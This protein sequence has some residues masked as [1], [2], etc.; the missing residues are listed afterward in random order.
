M[1]KIYQKLYIKNTYGIACPINR[2]LMQN[3]VFDIFFGHDSISS[4]RKLNKWSIKTIWTP[5]WLYLA[6]RQDFWSENVKSKSVGHDRFLVA[7]K[8]CSQELLKKIWIPPSKRA[9]GNN[10]EK[11]IESWKDRKMGENFRNIEKEI[12][13]RVTLGS[14]PIPSYDGVRRYWVIPNVNDLDRSSG[15]KCLSDRRAFCLFGFWTAS[16]CSQSY[17]TVSTFLSNSFK[18]NYCILRLEKGF[19][20]V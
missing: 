17:Q 13:R 8:K 9:E 3:L 6:E 16:P 4:A 7:K 19:Q 15:G 14:E 18:S 2:A 1:E 20:N 12:E 5:G 11:A 10:N